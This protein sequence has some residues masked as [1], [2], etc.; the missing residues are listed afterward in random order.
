M[1]KGISFIL[2]VLMMSSA[3]AAGDISLSFGNDKYSFGLS[4]NDDDNL[5]FL[6]CVRAEWENWHVSADISGYTNR[7]WKTGWSAEDSAVEDSDSSHFYSGRLDTVSLSAGFDVLCDVPPFSF[8]LIPEAGIILSGNLSQAWV[9]NAFH[10]VSGVRTLELDYDYAD[11][12]IHPLMELEGKV[13]YSPFSFFSVSLETKGRYAC[14]FEADADVSLSLSAVKN[15]KDVFS[16]FS[17]WRWRRNLSSSDTM[18]LYTEY[19]RGPYA[20]L[21]FDYGFFTAS[22]M[23]ELENHFGYGILTFHPLEF[24]VSSGWEKSDILFTTGFSRLVGIMFQEQDVE[25]PLSGS[26]S[27]LLR[28]RYIAGYPISWERDSTYNPQT[29]GRIKQGYVMNTAGLSYSFSLLSGWLRPYVSVSLGYMKWNVTELRNMMPSSSVP[30][31]P[32]VSD[33]ADYSFVIDAETGVRIIP[34]GLLSFSDVSVSVIPT[35][36]VSFVTGDFVS[37]YRNVSEKRGEK[38]KSPMDKFLFHWGILISF[39]LDL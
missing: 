34:D 31:L 13:S 12:R 8:S 19:V 22:Y 20:G 29:D 9:Q 2:I 4:R 38:E 7:G 28:N 17:G 25:I 39:G 21:S 3:V 10:T 32:Y 11:M 15:G 36:G 14:G 27:F 37:L 5:S 6:E 23:T 35:L 26:L 30:S 1:K 18:A 16:V 33:G 24:F